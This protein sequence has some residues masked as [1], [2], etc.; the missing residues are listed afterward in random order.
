MELVAALLRPALTSSRRV[1]VKLVA[2]LLRPALTGRLAVLV[3]LV[4]TLLR[5]APALTGRRRAS[6][7]AC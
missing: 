6:G 4:A 1:R 5:P 3:E 7:A 2:A